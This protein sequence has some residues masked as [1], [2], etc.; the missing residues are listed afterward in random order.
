MWRFLLLDFA[1]AA[2][3]ASILARGRPGR[4]GGARLPWRALRWRLAAGTVVALAGMTCWVAV[5]LTRTPWS[6]S[7]P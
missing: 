1:I 2:V 6:D 4:E 5:L 7:P 3:L